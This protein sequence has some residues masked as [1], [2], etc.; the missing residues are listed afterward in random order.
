[1]TLFP[2]PKSNVQL[3]FPYFDIHSA[4]P[5]FDNS[6]SPCSHLPCPMTMR[7][8]SEMAADRH[9]QGQSKRNADRHRLTSGGQAVCNI[10][11]DDYHLGFLSCGSYCSTV[12]HNKGM[13]FSASAQPGIL[14]IHFASTS[15]CLRHINKNTHM[16]IHQRSY[17]HKPHQKL[18]RYPTAF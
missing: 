18:F 14:C 15:Q 13:S 2:T 12:Q 3:V 5:F 11:G 9:N 4:L 1:M 17:C 16:I 7:K 6:S 8:R 10:K